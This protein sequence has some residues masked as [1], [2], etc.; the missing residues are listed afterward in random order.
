MKLRTW[1]TLAAASAL[2][3]LPTVASADTTVKA[4]LVELN[5]SGARAPSS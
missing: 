1:L 5:G 2:L 4:D 3:S